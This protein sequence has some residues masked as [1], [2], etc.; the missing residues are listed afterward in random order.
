MFDSGTK[1][2]GWEQKRQTRG[3]ERV[4]GKDAS[5][6][7]IVETWEEVQKSNLTKGEGVNVGNPRLRIGWGSYFSKSNMM[8][9]KYSC[10]RVRTPTPFLWA[11]HL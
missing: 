10:W 5:A 8:A 11:E 6:A 9:V 1:G 3:W 2:W 4:G 7:R